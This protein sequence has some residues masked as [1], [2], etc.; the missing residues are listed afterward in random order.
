MSLKSL[1]GKLIK[2]KKSSP[3][4]LNVNQSRFVRPKQEVR[5]SYDGFFR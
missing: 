1:T 3:P 2:I 5:R 4:K